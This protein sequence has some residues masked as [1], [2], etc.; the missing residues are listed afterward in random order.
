MD[1]FLWSQVLAGMTLVT[2]MAAF[3]F[4]ERV[5]M[6]RLWALAATFAA[7]HFY[8]LGSTAA[9]ILVGVT[10]L[11]F[12]VSSVTTDKRLMWLFLSLAVAGFAFTYVGP[13]SLLPLFA[14][15]VG[16]VGSFHGSGN[17]VRYS[18]MVAEGTWI[19]F[20][21]IIWSPV[22]IV[23]EV[24]FFISNLVGLIRH[25]KAEDATL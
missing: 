24:L 22:A 5:T 10:V 12:L 2:G 9:A 11:R 14:T 23:M 16:T 3:Q 13:V 19:V 18:S 6:L 25:R 15:L 8:L 7:V 4:R 1:A 17:A 20:D 21:I